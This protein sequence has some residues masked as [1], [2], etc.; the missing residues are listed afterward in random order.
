MTNFLWKGWEWFAYNHCKNTSDAD[1]H[2]YYA[3][4]VTKTADD[5]LFFYIKYAPQKFDNDQ[6]SDMREFG[7]AHIISSHVF[8]YGRFC[9]KAKLS[10]SPK[11]WE[12]IWLYGEEQC[13][14]EV[15]LVEA[16]PDHN[17]R[18]LGFPRTAWET[19]V[20]YNE[21]GKAVQ[22]GGK[23]ICS[24]WYLLTHRFNKADRWELDWTPKHIKIYFNGLCVRKITDPK[25]LETF[26]T[27]PHMRVV[28]NTMT[29]EGF[30]QEDY[31]RQTGMYLC[32][33]DYIPYIG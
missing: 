16:Y 8:S 28:V 31:T 24:L 18:V 33:F 19:N 5:K 32:D 7:C 10:N 22:S 17:G 6:L 25:I 26:N 12:A 11:T 30:G 27:N 4:N 2:S 13:P 9:F 14:P 1:R 29:Q 3:E 15:D 21:G 20:H 23:G